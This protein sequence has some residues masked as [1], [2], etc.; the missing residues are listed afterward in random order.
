M[1]L[2][3]V[4]PWPVFLVVLLV[5]FAV[6][7]LELARL[8]SWRPL[9]ILGGALY[10]GLGLAALG[11]LWANAHPWL[12]AVIIATWAADTVAY[13]VGS[14]IGRHR[15]A[16]RISPGKTWEGSIAGFAAAAGVIA[17]IGMAGPVGIIVAVGIGPVGLA[18]DLFESW[19]KR[20]AGAKDSG[21]LLPGHG[22]VLDRV[23]SLLFAGPFV[24]AVLAVFGGA[25]GM[26]GR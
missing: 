11:A 14:Q 21:S 12:L 19:L 13:L 20:R 10:L 15:L 24:W 9:H 8:A 22:G 1:L 7:I 25:D 6:A 3:A 16:P 18:G 23:D 5:L 2:G 17:A 26:M 4:G